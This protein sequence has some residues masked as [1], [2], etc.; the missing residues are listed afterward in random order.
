M[1]RPTQPLRQRFE[2]ASAPW[3]MRMQLLPGFVIPVLLALLLFLGLA[4][5]WAWTGLLLVSLGLF[6]SWLHAV[7][8]PALSNP[9]R[10]LRVTV[11]LGLLLLGFIRVTGG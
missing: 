9:A 8:W 11:T 3:L 7:S 10:A 5:P 6:L 1:T 2:A 4:L